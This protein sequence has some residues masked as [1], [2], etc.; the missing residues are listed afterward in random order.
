MP[1]FYTNAQAKGL[2]HPRS[3]QVIHEPPRR[4]TNQSSR[5]A[6]GIVLSFGLLA[7]LGGEA[8]AQPPGCPTPINRS[9]EEIRRWI[10]C[11]DA[12]LPD[13]MWRLIVGTANLGPLP[14]PD[15]DP[16]TA[17]AA[18]ERIAKE[19]LEAASK[20]SKLGQFA[21]VSTLDLWNTHASSLFQH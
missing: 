10:A 12:G 11:Y 5:L 21:V 19:Q 2:S 14:W 18:A 8:S 9:P 20:A 4:A 17:R 15:T 16:S 6:I 7:S 3:A 13:D 1:A